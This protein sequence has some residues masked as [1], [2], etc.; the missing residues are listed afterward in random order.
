VLVL[1]QSLFYWPSCNNSI[2]QSEKGKWKVEIC[3]NG[4]QGGRRGKRIDCVLRVVG[5]LGVWE[6]EQEEER[7]VLLEK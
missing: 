5:F 3:K 4:S 1:E 2:S 6:V 7:R